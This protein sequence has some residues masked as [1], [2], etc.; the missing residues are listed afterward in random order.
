MQSFPRGF[1]DSFQQGLLF[2]QRNP[3]GGGNDPTT[4]L[5]YPPCPCTP[6]NIHINS[7]TKSP[8]P[9]GHTLDQPLHW[10]LPGKKQM[11]RLKIA[12]KSS[13]TSCRII[14]ATLYLLK[15]FLHPHRPPSPTVNYFRSLIL[16]CTKKSH[17]EG[18]SA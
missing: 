6:T 13:F 12:Y 14:S 3:G 7:S 8:H 9:S 2:G 17:F 15:G 16:P 4:F 11:T 18:C 1:R 5:Q 10:A